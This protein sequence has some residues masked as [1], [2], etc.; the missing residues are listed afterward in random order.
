MGV[1]STSKAI[2]THEPDRNTVILGLYKNNKTPDAPI[3][4]QID[5]G[6]QKNEITENTVIPNKLP[7]K[8]QLYAIRLERLI[9]NRDGN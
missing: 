4:N 2:A 8:F 7:N 5:G 1:K 6:D 9:I 3:N